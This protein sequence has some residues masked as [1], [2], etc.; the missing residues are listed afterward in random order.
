MRGAFILSPSRSLMRPLSATWS[1]HAEYQIS[2][3]HH[4]AT[5]DSAGFRVL[6]AYRRSKQSCSSRNPAGVLAQSHE[7]AMRTPQGSKSSCV[8]FKAYEKI[9]A[10]RPD[11]F[12]HVDAARVS[13]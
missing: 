4:L 10:T 6:S 11:A 9:V 12:E 1:R 2:R 13:V 5:P 8:D 3:R 7:S